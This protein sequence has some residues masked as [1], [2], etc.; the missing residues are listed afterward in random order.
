[1]AMRTTLRTV[2]RRADPFAFEFVN[3]GKFISA[4]KGMH[5]TRTISDT[6]LVFVTAGSLGIRVGERA[7]DLGPGRFLLLP[8]GV[9]HGGTR[10]YS[11]DLSFYW[12]HMRPDEARQ[13]AFPAT[14]TAARYE[15][16]AFWCDALLSEQRVPGN[17]EICNR[18]LAIVFCELARP[19][20]SPDGPDCGTARGGEVLASAALKRLRLDFRSS[21]CSTATIA[22]ALRCNPD[23]LGRVYRKRFGETLTETVESMRLAHAETLLRTTML[24]VSQISDDAGYASPS[25]FRRRF[26]LRHSVSPK[27]WRKAHTDAVAHVNSV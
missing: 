20:L 14:G 8:A 2:G 23:Y 26:K 1:M 16:V 22:D 10:P 3:M 21:R 5:K 6:E 15:A 11:R 9:E 4:G 12:I 7:Y 19:P 17:G 13:R 25:Y 24:T 18:L 27:A